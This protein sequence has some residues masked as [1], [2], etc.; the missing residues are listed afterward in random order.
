[1]SD[2]SGSADWAPYCGPGPAPGEWLARW[3]LDPLLWLALSGLVFAW[4]LHADDTKSRPAFLVAMALLFVLFVSPLCA[5]TS[6]L[7]AARA[8]HH[9]ILVAVAAPMLA[10]SFPGVPKRGLL[11]LVPLT[12]AH[13]A[14]LWAWHV[15][16]LYSSALSS[17]A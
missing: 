4:M 11:A 3:N 14:V 1:V 10:L 16:S 5:L 7:F 6:A 9:A 8:A 15:P 13:A 17:D 12:F 2:R